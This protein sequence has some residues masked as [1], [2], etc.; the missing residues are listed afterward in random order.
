MF[1]LGKLFLFSGNDIDLQVSVEGKLQLGDLEDI[2]LN[3][4]ALHLTYGVI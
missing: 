2:G 3:M 4:T 1:T